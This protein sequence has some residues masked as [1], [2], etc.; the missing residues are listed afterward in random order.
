MISIRRAKASQLVE[1]AL[2]LNIG[3]L[4]RAGVLRPWPTSGQLTWTLA[5]GQRAS[6]NFQAHLAGG[7][8][9]LDF[10][11]WGRQ[12]RQTIAFATTEPH[13]GGAFISFLNDGE[14]DLVAM[15][16]RNGPGD[17]GKN[18]SPI[19]FP[20]I[21]PKLASH[22]FDVVAGRCFLWALRRLRLRALNLRLRTNRP[23]E[24]RRGMAVQ[25][26]RRTLT[27]HPSCCLLSYAY[28]SPLS[29]VRD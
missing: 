9:Q 18:L 23:W 10:T 19:V 20:P 1:H 3:Q 13:F 29:R 27:D 12:A 15:V 14:A 25:Q 17:L 26:R 24:R 4:I 6:V 21:G 7:Y 28:S 11:V 8:L 22:K 2:T 16:E 5:R